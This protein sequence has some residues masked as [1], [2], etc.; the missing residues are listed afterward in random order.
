MLLL[1]EGLELAVPL[2]DDA[3][4]VGEERPRGASLRRAEQG[5]ADDQYCSAQSRFSFLPNLTFSCQF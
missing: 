3:R 1:V 2:V 5:D 4:I